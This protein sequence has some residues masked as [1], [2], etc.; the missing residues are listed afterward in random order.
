MEK[1][2]LSTSQLCCLTSLC[3]AAIELYCFHW[4]KTFIAEHSL[5]DTIFEQLQHFF[6]ELKPIYSISYVIIYLLL[7]YVARFWL[8]LFIIILGIQSVS[9][10]C[11]SAIIIHFLKNKQP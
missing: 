5:N 8:Y 10:L 11:N 6:N 4:I 2:G 9:L 7:L 3:L 1:L